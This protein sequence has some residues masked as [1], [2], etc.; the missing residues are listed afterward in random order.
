V[1]VIVA[2]EPDSKAVQRHVCQDGKLIITME[3][4]DNLEIEEWFPTKE[5]SEM[6]NT[7]V[8]TGSASHSSS[9][10]G[11]Q[12]P[13]HINTFRSMDAIPMGLGTHKEEPNAPS[14][15][16]IRIDDPRNRKFVE[17]LTTGAVFKKFKRT[18]AI[19]RIIF[20][21][22]DLSKLAWSLPA[23][24]KTIQGFI[25]SRDIF[26]IETG[27]GKNKLKI[28]VVAKSRILELE[29][30]DISTLNDWVRSLRFLVE[31]T[32]SDEEEEQRRMQ[33]PELAIFHKK[34]MET[35]KLLLVKGEVFN[36]INRS[37]SV[38]RTVYCTPALD[39]LVWKDADGVKIRGEVPLEDIVQVTSEKSKND[40]KLCILSKK[41][42]I[43]LEAK[44][45]ETKE[46]FI[47]A[48]SFYIKHPR[49]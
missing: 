41:N 7:I 19:K 40:N 21:S 3:F 4:A 8:Q 16:V 29:A 28:F 48:L 20:C 36:K 17:T 25:H 37:T 30:E 14:F 45:S 31:Y 18:S 43:V 47:N 46:R 9:Q 34:M 22:N 23:N 32:K 26:E 15:Q 49:Q 11:S 24:K 1:E 42:V 13:S 44:D 33:I 6:L 2:V 27:Y 39:R 35:Y 5:L 38:E 12:G 10:V